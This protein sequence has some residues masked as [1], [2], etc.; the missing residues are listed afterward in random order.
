MER[1]VRKE[2]FS[3]RISDKKYL[4][5]KSSGGSIRI[6][7]QEFYRKGSSLDTLLQSGNFLI[8][9]FQERLR[10]FLK[11]L[12]AASAFGYCLLEETLVFVDD[13][14]FVAHVLDEMQEQG[15]G[16]CIFNVCIFYWISWSI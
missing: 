15:E 10:F 16:G 11:G 5:L 6:F 7:L 1:T 4:P 9:L 8:G 14:G 13:H 2:I 3:S 12:F